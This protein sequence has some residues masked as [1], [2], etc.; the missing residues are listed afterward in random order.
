MTDAE[1]ALL[2]AVAHATHQLAHIV[3]AHEHRDVIQGHLEAID[4]ETAS[5]D[6]PAA[7]EHEHQHDHGDEQP[8]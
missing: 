6:E 2:L 4:A 1:R 7:V 3:G 8:E 5:L